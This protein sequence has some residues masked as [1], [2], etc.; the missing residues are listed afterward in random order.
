MP[1]YSIKMYKTINCLVL[2]SS[3]SDQLYLEL[4]LNQIP[5]L[6]IIYVNTTAEFC[7]AIAEESF[8][9]YWIDIINIGLISLIKATFPC[10]FICGNTDKFMCEEIYKQFFPINFYVT[11]PFNEHFIKTQIDNF[12]HINFKQD[13]QNLLF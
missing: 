7:D 9:F 4:I 13:R 10:L 5:E 6:D 1:N 3:L 12:I 8:H 11:K 2:E